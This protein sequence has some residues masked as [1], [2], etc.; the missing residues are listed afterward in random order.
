MFR[1]LLIANRGE[2]AARVLRTAH[3]M[4]IR[5]V[6]V[7]SAADADAR[8]L[9]DADEVVR[10]GGARSA[11]SYLDEDA[12]LEAALRT[13]ATAIHPGWGFLS[14]NER[15]AVRAR[16]AGLTFIGPDPRHLRA[17]GDKALA[18]ATMRSL[19]LPL[20]PGSDGEVASV[21][22]ARRL[23]D[24]FGYPVLLK[25]VAGG[26]GRGMR[27]VDRPE[28]LERAFSE[29]QAEAIGAFGDGRLYLEKRIVGGRHVEVQVF[30]DRHGHA[31]AI[32]ERECSLQRRHQKVLEEAPSP[33][34]SASERERILPLIGEAMAKAGYVGAGTIE[35][36]LDADGRLYFMEMNTRLQVEHPVTEMIT[37]LDLVEWQLRVAAN[38]PLPAG[39]VSSAGHAIEC[40]IN[41]EDPDNGFAPCPGLI[42]A[43]HLPTGDGVR[44]DTHLRGGDRIPP[45]YDSM[46][47]KVIVRGEDR[48]D[49]I[50]RMEAALAA[51]VVRGPKTNIALHRRI[52]SWDAFRSGHYDTTSLERLVSGAH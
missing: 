12:I 49:A 3:R 30:G 43:L 29:A 24:D 22:A 41:A 44:V 10:I 6:A 42:E 36:L 39:T 16:A 25:A 26:G 17:M 46:I 18:K 45:N 23:A 9:A 19:G 40:R 11:Q 21:D 32:G 14:E 34:L 5:V 28:D 35:M 20:I 50:R 51:L 38:E 33:G 1:K 15:F 27:G 52:L 37:G 7:A 31:I 2:V 47:A 48:A 8:W 4:G 13:G